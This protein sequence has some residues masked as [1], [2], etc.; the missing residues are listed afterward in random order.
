VDDETFLAF[1][2][3]NAPRCEIETLRKAIAKLKDNIASRVFRRPAGLEVGSNIEATDFDG[4]FSVTVPLYD[5]PTA[6]ALS[7]RQVVDIRTEYRS[8]HR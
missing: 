2:V 1:L 6:V 3:N 8:R 7:S 5:C 4:G